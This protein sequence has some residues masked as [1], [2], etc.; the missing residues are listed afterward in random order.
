VFWQ[1]PFYRT[2]M[3]DKDSGDGGDEHSFVL[4]EES[5]TEMRDAEHTHTFTAQS[6]DDKQNWMMDILVG[7]K[8]MHHV[9]GIFMS[10]LI[11]SL[12]LT[13]SFAIDSVWNSARLFDEHRAR[14]WP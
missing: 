8:E 10:S 7:M 11:I 9:Q 13:H 5:S 1:I 6:A 14:S 3:H 12:S 4:V 2:V